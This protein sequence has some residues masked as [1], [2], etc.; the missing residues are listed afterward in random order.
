MCAAQP[1]RHRVRGAVGGSK[2]GTKQERRLGDDLRLEAVRRNHRYLFEP[3]PRRRSGARIDEVMQAPGPPR[4]LA[5]PPLKWRGV[6]PLL[7]APH[8]PSRAAGRG[9]PAP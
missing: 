4:P 9:T 2:V 3:G 5:P 6:S 1:P 7:L 8:P